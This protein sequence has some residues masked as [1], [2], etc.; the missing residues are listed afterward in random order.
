MTDHV[1]AIGIVDEAIYLADRIAIMTL[2][3]FSKWTNSTPRSQPCVSAG[4]F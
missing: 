2:N 3:G 1:L 4:K